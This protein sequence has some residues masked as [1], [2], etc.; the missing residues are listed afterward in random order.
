ME[1]RH[2]Q[3]SQSAANKPCPKVC[4]SHT[5]PIILQKTTSLL[6][7]VRLPQYWYSV[8][9]QLNSSNPPSTAHDITPNDKASFPP[10]SR[11]RINWWKSIFSPYFQKNA[12]LSMGI[13]IRH[14]RWMSLFW[15]E[16]KQFPLRCE[17]GWE[18]SRS[19]EVTIRLCSAPVKLCWASK[20]G[21]KPQLKG[22]VQKQATHLHIYRNSAGTLLLLW[23]TSQQ[24][25]L[26]LL[27]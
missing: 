12:D 27:V 10:A 22:D 25:T 7:I 15:W 26:H 13:R 23:S 16:T 21:S 11:I 2:G 4:I 3:A 5:E 24:W 18:L 19:A 17:T 9:W 14:Q 1:S 8:Y 6:C 20:S